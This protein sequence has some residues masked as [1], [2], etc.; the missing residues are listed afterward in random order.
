MARGIARELLAEFFGTFVLIV[1]GVGVVAQFVLSKGV[2]GSFLSINVAWGLAVTMG[3]YVSA[4]VTG[5]HLNPAVTLSLAAHRQ[6]PWRKVIPYSLAQLAG[7]FV[8]SA[9]VYLTYREALGAFDGGVRQVLGAQGTA[10]IW[11]TYPRPFLSTFPG[12]FIDQVVGTALLV[13]VIFGITDSRNSPAPAGL[14]PVVVGLLVV[15]IGATF[16][17]NAGY[18]INPA[19]DFGP[20][21]FTF[22]AGWGGEV[23]RAGN[24]WWWVPIVAPCVGGVVGGWVYDACIGHRFASHDVAP[25]IA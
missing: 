24:H 12:G 1:F 11:A 7:A 8:A 19:R 9:V 10:G 2:A 20:R 5:A 22:L 18:A 21:L 25:E 15:L 6:F 3:C 23:F 13:A 16:G 14:A 17:F 4:G